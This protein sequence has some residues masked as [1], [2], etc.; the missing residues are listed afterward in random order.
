M[1]NGE[2]SKRE[3]KRSLLGRKKKF[4]EGSYSISLP[5]TYVI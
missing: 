5:H 1:A 4:W 3:R 2:M